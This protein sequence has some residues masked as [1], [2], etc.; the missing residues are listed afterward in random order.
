MTIKTKIKILREITKAGI[1]DCKNAIILSKS[2]F[3]RAIKVIKDKEFLKIHKIFV[4]LTNENIISNY[5]HYN[6]SLGVLL[7]LS[8]QTDFVAKNKKFQ[9]LGYCLAKQI[10]LLR[11]VKYLSFFAIPKNIIIAETLN[12]NKKQLIFSKKNNMSL[13]TFKL[14]NIIFN[15]KPY[16]LLKQSL[17]FEDELNIENYII[18]CMA[19]FGE[20]VR[21]KKFI[22]YTSIE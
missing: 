1:L 4:N 16:I 20:N 12:C 10:S 14:K 11:D 19:L 21:L 22:K 18:N 5:Y 3:N 2:D 9:N 15:L 8:C 7:E 17:F 13:T 6:S